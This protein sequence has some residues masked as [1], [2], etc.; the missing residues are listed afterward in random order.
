[1]A[2]GW[3]VVTFSDGPQQFV[4][5]TQN[6][7][8]TGVYKRTNEMKRKI[9]RG[10]KGKK[11]AL[12]KH[13]LLSEETKGKMSQSR[14]GRRLSE[15]YKI[16]L[17]LAQKERYKD[18]KEREKTSS[19]MKGRKFSDEHRRKISIARKGKYSPGT[20]FQKGHKVS[21]EMRRKI[22]QAQMGRRL[23]EETK[24]KLSEA[25]KGPKHP[26]WGKHHT[27]ET[28][29]KMRNIK[30]KLY[31]NNSEL[32]DKI[33]NSVKELWQ[34]KD[35]IEKHCGERN[36]NWKGGLTKRQETLAHALRV[37]LK[38]WAKQVLERDNYICQKCGIGFKE[39]GIMQVHHI[40]SVSKYPSL[41]LDIAN[42]IT[43]CKNCHRKTE[44]YGRKL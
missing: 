40:K 10:M 29:N 5:G 36:P 13:W 6:N 11:N 19:A 12:G 1:M 16:K 35:Y 14:I 7:M 2:L 20:G 24:R 3:I 27:E 28:K 38:N 43:L 32:I 37:E 15:E 33:S 39:K 44:S 8:P 42:G 34:N 4:N 30:I 41:V 22:S 21:E 18:P 26:L 9:S 25:N 31:R 17:S 23:S